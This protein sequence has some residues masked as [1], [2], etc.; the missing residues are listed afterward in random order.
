MCVTSS[1]H[2]QKELAKFPSQPQ[3][4]PGSVLLLDRRDKESSI[5][6]ERLSERRVGKSVY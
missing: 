2:F 1:L 3:C 4:C 5:I 6:S